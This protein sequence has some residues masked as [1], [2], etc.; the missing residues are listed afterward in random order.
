[1]GTGV[2][3]VLP[4]GPFFQ[5]LAIV[6]IVPLVCGIV[7]QAASRDF[8]AK[9]AVLV[10]GISLVGFFCVFFAQGYRD[11]PTILEWFPHLGG[12]TLC[13]A[14]TGAGTAILFAKLLELPREHQIAV[15]QSLLFQD[16][17]VIVGLLA[18]VLG[19]AEIV[20]IPAMVYGL[21]QYILGF[22]LVG[23]GRRLMA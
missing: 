14:L 15:T 10:K 21:T 19:G 22:M 20:L 12:A 16:T 3:Y 6:V 17:F 1:M 7:F 4:G 5:Q 23:W 11:L 13:T 9:Y 18:A 2:A 8:V